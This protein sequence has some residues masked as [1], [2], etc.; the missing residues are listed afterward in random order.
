[1]GEDVVSKEDHPTGPVGEK[2]NERVS[3]VFAA[4]NREEKKPEHVIDEYQ[5]I[6]S[7][8]SG[9][10]GAG[11]G[12]GDAEAWLQG[13]GDLWNPEGD[14]PGEDNVERVSRLSVDSPGVVK[15]EDDDHRDTIYEAS[16]AANLVRIIDGLRNE[17]CRLENL[18]S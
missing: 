16:T 9:G 2:S 1:M 13:D 5:I 11:A 15:R 10:R 3:P 18:T 7:D 14:N 4:C 8:M 12:A 17:A 6:A